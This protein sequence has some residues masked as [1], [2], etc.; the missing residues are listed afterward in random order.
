MR[1]GLLHQA[2]SIAQAIDPELV[3][4]LTFTAAD[5]ATPA[6]ALLRGN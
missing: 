3:A 2:R 4:R 1:A 6:F 5:R